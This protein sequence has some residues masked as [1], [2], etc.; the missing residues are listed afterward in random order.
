MRIILDSTALRRDYFLSSPDARLLELYVTKTQSSV[1]VP[2]V[3]VDEVRN[4]Y[5]EDLREVNEKLV[6]KYRQL[7]A[8]RAPQLPQLDPNQECEAYRT[9]IVSVIKKKFRGIVLPYPRLSHE[10]LVK[11][12]LP[13]RKGGD[14]A[15]KNP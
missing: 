7:L 1:V 9:H 6:S 8:I 2:K 13:R 12:D 10:D 5:R 3:V 15:H 4:L 11:R 14:P